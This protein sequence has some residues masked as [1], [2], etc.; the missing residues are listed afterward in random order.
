MS[1]GDKIIW[2]AGRPHLSN[3]ENTIIWVAGRPYVVIDSV[4]E[5]PAGIPVQAF[6]YYQRLRRQG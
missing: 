1:F 5:V 6:M 2:V 4:A 3:E